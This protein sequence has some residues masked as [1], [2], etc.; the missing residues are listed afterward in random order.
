MA[1]S[2]LIGVLTATFLIGRRGQPGHPVRPVQTAPQTELAGGI[3]FVSTADL[4]T[5]LD[6]AGVDDTVADA[7]VEENEEARIAGLRIS[8]A[9]LALIAVLALFCTRM[10]PTVPV[11]HDPEST[12]SV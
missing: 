4:E 1:G 10:I 5:A 2:V 8:L 6:D 12:T 7:V 11:G 9:V 3:P